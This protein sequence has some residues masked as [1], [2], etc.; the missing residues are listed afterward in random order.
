MQPIK[1]WTLFSLHGGIDLNNE[2]RE[3]KNARNLAI[4]LP[5]MG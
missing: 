1:Y 5:T 3:V 4:G 2:S